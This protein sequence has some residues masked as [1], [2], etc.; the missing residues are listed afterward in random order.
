[1]ARLSAVA[2]P[3]LSVRFVPTPSHERG[4]ARV[5]WTSQVPVAGIF[6][7]L[8]RDRAMLVVD[9]RSPGRVAGEVDALRTDLE[10]V[11]RWEIVAAKSWIDQ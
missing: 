5:Y 9:H 8:D 3:G 4:G 6:A 11:V 7:G 10:R 2:S 1:V